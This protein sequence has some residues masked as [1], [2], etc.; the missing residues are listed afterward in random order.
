MIRL[1][2]EV[3][4][5]ACSWLPMTFYSSEKGV[6]DRVAERREQKTSLWITLSRPTEFAYF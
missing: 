4:I 2:M 3:V 1:F 6:R 5:L